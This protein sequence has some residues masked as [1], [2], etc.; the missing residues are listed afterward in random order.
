MTTRT[1]NFVIVSLAVLG[2]G[3]G[4]GLVAYYVGFPAGALGR[5]GGP[6]E[7]SYLPRD[8]SAIAF[9]DVREIMTSE[10]RQKLRRALPA[11]ENGQ[12]ELETQTGI[13]IETDIDRVVACLYPDRE[14]ASKGAGMVLARGR[15][16]EVKIE[17]LMR[18]HGATVETYNGKRMVVANHLRNRDRDPDP[19]PSDSAPAPR[20]PSHTFAV[21]F[22]EPGLVAIG[23]TALIRSAIDLHRAG[24]NPQQGLESVTGNEELMNLVRSLDDGNA[25]AVG[26]FDALGSHAKLPA[27]VSS[28]I[29]AITWVSV[30][31]HVNGG[32]RGIV[33]AEARDDEAA[34]NLRDVV[35]GFLALAKLQSG[36]RPELQMMMQSL[37]MTGTGKTVGLSF[38]VPAEV[39]D[40]VGALANKTIRPEADPR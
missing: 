26:R 21:S 6:D 24:N 22:M 10:L 30:S 36:S 23:S 11:Q 37:E 14:G 29:P 15:F 3:L 9:A 13:N 4:T 1:R 19:D 31:G 20:N 5:Q 16:D 25:W 40:L 12:R 18:E 27:A 8:A 34:N 35:R 17:A 32:I 28:Q 7:L 39:F 2:I 38:A 33:R